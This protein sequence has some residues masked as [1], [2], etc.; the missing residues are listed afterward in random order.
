MASKEVEDKKP[1]NKTEEPHKEVEDKKPDNETE[2]PPVKNVESKAMNE[3]ETKVMNALEAFKSLEP[4]MRDMLELSINEFAQKLWGKGLIPDS[5]H[6]LI[7]DE[8]AGNG[9]RIRSYNFL[10]SIYKKAYL[11]NKKKLGKHKEIINAV[12]DIIG[13]DAALHDAAET[14]SKIIIY[15]DMVLA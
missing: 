2:K 7:F 8:G 13:D 14:L 3:Q 12:A 9:S 10:M 11:A 4:S 6:E 1:V 5:V 15:N